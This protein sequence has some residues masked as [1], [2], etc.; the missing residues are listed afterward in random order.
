MLIAAH[1]RGASTPSKP[2][3]TKGP[4][5]DEPTREQVL[6][7]LAEASELE[8]NLLCSYLFALF[9]L[10]DETAGDLLPEE[11]A[12]IARWR[13][14]LRGVCIEEMLH[15]AQVANLSVAV[16]ATPHFNRPNLPVAA[17]Y[18]PAAVVVELTG[19][20]LE[21]L[22]HFIHLERPEG[23][24]SPDGAS[25]TP[26]VACRREALPGMLMPASP[27]YQT[28]GEFYAALQEKLSSFCA[29][30][31]EHRLFIGAADLQMRPAEIKSDSLH[32]VEDLAT[33]RAAI[34]EIVRQGEGA[35]GASTES[36]FSQFTG[37]QKEYEAHLAARPEFAPAYPV[38]R[39][40]VMRF[41]VA[42]GRTHVT[43]PQAFLLLDASNA[44]YNFMLRCL[45]AC[46]QSPW[47][48]APAREG[49]L[50]ATFKAMKALAIVG[51]ELAKL[52]ATEDGSDPAHAG[53]S[54]AMMRSTEGLDKACRDRALRERARELASHVPALALPAK[55]GA[56]L[57]LALDE[58]LAALPDG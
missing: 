34:E 13:S 37:V 43:H 23:T 57:A 20:D 18:H 55:A 28:I 47:G 52:P 10:K 24:D 6:H 42:A 50:T 15:L 21:T 16:G 29:S 5:T 38:G 32:V 2:P 51:S 17:G 31:G 7:L 41:P 1:S 27:D 3:L 22:Q 9:S 39:N 54:F 12:S 33:A 49:L 26:D 45:A 35:P 56:A 4:V 46:Y 53:V 36:H 58:V 14:T 8:H 40:P 19:F 48:Q 44:I 11:C 25:F 30:H